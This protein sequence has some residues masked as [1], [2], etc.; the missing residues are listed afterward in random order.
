ML[1][2]TTLPL[3]KHDACCTVALATNGITRSIWWARA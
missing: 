2:H 1:L 3:G